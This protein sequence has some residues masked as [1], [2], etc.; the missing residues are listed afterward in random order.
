VLRRLRRI[1]RYVETEVVE[2]DG[3]Y[4]YSSHNIEVN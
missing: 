4:M 2:V 3:L 1:F